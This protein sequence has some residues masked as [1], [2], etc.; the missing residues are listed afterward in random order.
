MSYCELWVGGL[1]GGEQGGLN[2]VLYVID[3]L[4]GGGG[5]GL[6]ELL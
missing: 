1:G 4:D 6:N 2:E 3:G 5:D